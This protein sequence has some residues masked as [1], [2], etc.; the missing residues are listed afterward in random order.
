MKLISEN[1]PL[2][3]NLIVE[4]YKVNELKKEVAKVK[5][6]FQASKLKRAQVVKLILDNRDLFLHFF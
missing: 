2:F 3:P 5:K 6:E 4:K 1:R